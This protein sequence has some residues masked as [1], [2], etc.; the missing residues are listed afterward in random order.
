P[1]THELAKAVANKVKDRCGIVY[2]KRYGVVAVSD[3]L[4]MALELAE[5]AEVIAA[6]N[7]FF[8][9]TANLLKV[10]V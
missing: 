4:G 9:G 7:N 1:K 2:L 5:L 6:R 10:I 3:N 8:A